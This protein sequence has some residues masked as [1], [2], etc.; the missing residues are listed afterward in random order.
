MTAT[1]AFDADFAPTRGLAADRA[2]GRD[3]AFVDALA[4]DLAVFNEAAAGFATRVVFFAG[5]CGFEVRATA[6][7]FTG[8][9]AEFLIESLETLNF[10]ADA[11]DTSR[12]LRSNKSN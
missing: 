3:A 6:R 7:V 8:F 10:E 12:E 11:G 4:D 2:D 1:F 5:V 9:G